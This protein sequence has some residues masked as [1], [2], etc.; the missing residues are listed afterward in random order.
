M[1]NKLKESNSVPAEKPSRSTR[2]RKGKSGNP[3]GLPKWLWV[4]IDPA[5][6][7]EALDK[8]QLNII[9]NGRRKRMSKIEISFRQMFKVAIKGNGD[10][11]ALRNLLRAMEEYSAP[12]VQQGDVKLISKAQAKR[13]FGKEWRK[14]VT[15]SSGQPDDK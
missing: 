10:I 5:S 4:Q 2:Y 13:L 7:L 3:S 15:D 9:E 11:R 12:S 8:E 6:I 1:S 14:Y